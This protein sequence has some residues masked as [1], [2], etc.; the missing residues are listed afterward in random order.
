MADNL[1]DRLQQFF[2]FKTTKVDTGFNKEK[3]IVEPLNKKDTNSDKKLSSVKKAN[4]SS[5]AKRLW[6]W[7][8]SQTSDGSETLKSR[9]DRYKDLDYMVFN[10]TI[11]S[12]SVDLYADE[13]A[14]ADDQ[15]SLIKADAKDTKVKKEIDRLL[16]VWGI[17]QNYI[18]RLLII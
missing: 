2:G 12:F 14:Q 8:T 10:D 13:A 5:D 3:V 9:N 16:G 15:F 1:I 17:D 6:D 11:F 18:E 7:Y 4:F